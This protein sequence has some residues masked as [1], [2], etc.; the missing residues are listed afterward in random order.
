[1]TGADLAPIPIETEKQPFFAPAF[2][3][4]VNGKKVPLSAV[5]DVMEVTYEDGTE[6]ID[7]FSLTV[8]N[9]DAAHRS[10]IYFGRKKGDPT[11]DEPDLFTP[12]NELM[13]YMGY[14]GDKRLMMTGFITTVDVQFPETGPSKLVV[15]GLNVL[16]RLRRKQYTWSWP[17]DGSKSVRDS[18]VARA[19]AAPPND[20]QNR[21]GL[22]IEVR[23]DE[24]A[25]RQEPSVDNIF[26]NNQYPIVFLMELA[27]R[28][29][30]EVLMDEEIDENNK[31]KKFVYFGRIQ[32]SH[33]VTYK[34]EWGKSL[35][36]FHPKFSSAKQLFSVT[37]CGWDR[38][39]KKRIE[40]KRTLDQV[41]GVNDDLKAVARAANREEVITE[42]PARTTA[43]A[44]KKAEDLLSQNLSTMV[45][46]TGATVGLPDLRSGRMVVID[47]TGQPF[48]GRYRVLT[49]AH[50]LNDSGYRTTFSARRVG[51]IEGDGEGGAP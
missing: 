1:M 47:G 51:P 35:A 23:I 6:R 40:V 18:D 39:A 14:Q 34:L 16:D 31:R 48:K 50:I 38:K 13:L 43:E 45:E 22:G 30:Y 26:M 12:G 2:E 20:A 24:E 19:L 41:K 49:S 28:R 8:N 4:Y 42:P 5:R 9:W 10:P 46:A 3:L 15:T 44:T 36:S 27:R 33:N 11:P 21:P 32:S 7:S 29:G 17:D 37:V 25:A